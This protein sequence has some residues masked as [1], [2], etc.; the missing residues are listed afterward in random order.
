[1]IR[2]DQGK[3][4]VALSLAGVLVLM[5][6]AAARADLPEASDSETR[7]QGGGVSL[8]Q[9]LEGQTQEQQ[10]LAQ[11]ATLSQTLSELSVPEG[12]SFTERPDYTSQI[13]LGGEFSA[14][15]HLTNTFPEAK[16]VNLLVAFTPPGTTDTRETYHPF[17]VNPGE[18]FP[19][20]R[21]SGERLLQSGITP[22][23]YAI[24]FAAFQKETRLGQGFFGNPFAFGQARIGSAGNPVIPRSVPAD[25]DLVVEFPFS[26]TGDTAGKVY[27]FL[28]FTA[29]GALTTREVYATNLIVPAGGITHRVVFTQEQLRQAGV[30]P[31]QWLVT[32]GALDDTDSLLFRHPGNLL[33]I[34]TPQ[35]TFTTPPAYTSQL[36]TGEPLQVTFQVG[37][38]GDVAAL[39][40]LVTIL[41]PI[42]SDPNDPGVYTEFYRA[43]MVQP[44]GGS[45]LQE[46]DLAS[47]GLPAG[48]YMLSF[49]V[50]DLRDGSVGPQENPAERGF[51]GRL[52]QVGTFQ[53]AFHARPTYT[54]PIPVNEPFRAQFRIEN[55]GDAP[56]LAQLVTVFRP[57]PSDANN[58]SVYRE[59][60]QALQV[61]PGG[62]VFEQ[63][64][65]LAQAGLD[66]RLHIVTFRVLDVK[67]TPIGDAENPS[68]RGFF[69]NRVTVA[70]AR[71][72]SL[73]NLFF[74]AQDWARLNLSPLLHKD[75]L[76]EALTRF[77]TNHQAE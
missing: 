72:S 38:T 76:F 33:D 40:Q 5:P 10:D 6:G 9:M 19:E 56:G 35:P 23:R 52:L 41:R 61:P 47:K 50:L 73:S 37:N 57:I 51:F 27:V 36:P 13:G 26:N 24:T 16:E 15:F 66:P 29:P 11:R 34:G 22:G 74:T 2:A 49:R 65:D 42:P 67:D 21:I 69:G 18:S 75:I 7:I 55:D 17:T 8:D 14:R 44:G 43:V 45:F 59:S 4:A 31:G 60:Y 68:G 30:T 70:P 63:T 3:R 64:V 77:L 46:I 32:S 58:P 12:L 1:M 71:S 39:A 53:P 28:G 48:P 62:A 54:E 20:V 25:Q